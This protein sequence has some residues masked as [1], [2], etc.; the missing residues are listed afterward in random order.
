MR[1]EAQK[2]ED[3]GVYRVSRLHTFDEKTFVQLVE[4]KGRVGEHYHSIQTEVFVIVEGSGRIGI[5]D[6]VFSVRCGDVL[7]CEPGKVHFAEGE[8]KVLV[9][10][11][12]YAENDS[13]WINLSSP[14]GE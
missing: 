3:R 13:H 14:G 11:Y 10:K 2:W 8:M 1:L 4:I 5:G 9:F 12:N 7:L 6:E